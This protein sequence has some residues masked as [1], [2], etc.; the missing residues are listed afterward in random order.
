MAL[1]EVYY[2]RERHLNSRSRNK[3]IKKEFEAAEPLLRATE[4]IVGDIFEYR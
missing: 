2:V 1:T 4:G 3:S